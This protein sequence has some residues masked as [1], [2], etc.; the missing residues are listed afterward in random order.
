MI[1]RFESLLKMLGINLRQTYWFFSQIYPYFYDR[2]VLKKQVTNNDFPFGKAY[3][4]LFDVKSESGTANG[5]YF[6]QDLLVSQCIFSANPKKHV[7]IGSSVGGFVAHIASYRKIE[8]FDIRPLESTVSNI[9]FRQA[10]MMS[11]IDKSF[12]EYC[13]S[14]SCLHALEHFGLGRYGD[15]IKYDGYMDGINNI[16]QM[17]KPNGKLYL[18]VPIGPQRIE[19]NAHRV[20]SVKFMIDEVLTGFSLDNFSYVDDNGDLHTNVSLSDNDLLQTNFGCGF[21]LGIFELKKIIS[22]IM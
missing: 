15:P 21:G 20:F 3:P 14:I 2:H 12:Y 22:E 4:M 10:D 5:H 7:D 11:N 17:L 8:V 13:D 6:H 9:V 1:K 19:F 18:S 16:Y